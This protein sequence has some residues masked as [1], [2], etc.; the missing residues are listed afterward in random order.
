MMNELTAG[1]KTVLTNIPHMGLSSW[2]LFRLDHI[3]KILVNSWFKK[4]H[5]E[6][7]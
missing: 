5:R 4:A 7:W 2:N 6:I 3:C 1:C